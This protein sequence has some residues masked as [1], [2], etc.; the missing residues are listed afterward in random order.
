[1]T[2]DESTWRPLY[3]QNVVLHSPGDISPKESS[4]EESQEIS[5]SSSARRAEQASLHRELEVL[6]AKIDDFH[7]R[8]PREVE[9]AADLEGS[10]LPVSS[11]SQEQL[12]L[13]TPSVTFAQALTRRKE[14]TPLAVCTVCTFAIFE[15]VPPDNQ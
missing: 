12:L 2:S 4:S 13:E 8:Y 14:A 10:S 6:T 11:D 9:R 5:A 7:R 1:V 3:F 15:I